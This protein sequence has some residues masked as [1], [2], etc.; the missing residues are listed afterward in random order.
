MI[1]IGDW[2]AALSVAPGVSYEYWLQ[3]TARYSAHLQSIAS[4]KAV[5]YLIAAGND[6]GAVDFYLKRNQP[7]PAMIVAK[8][9]ESR[10]TSTPSPVGGSSALSSNSGGSGGALARH[11]SAY[12]S[13]L[14][15]SASKPLLSAAQ[16]IASGEIQ[17]AVNLLYACEY[18]DIAFAVLVCSQMDTN[19]VKLQMASRCFKNSFMREGLEILS[20]CA[21]NE[22]E[23]GLLLSR[24]CENEKDIQQWLDHANLPTKLAVF[25]TRALEN[26]TIGSDIIA[27]IFYIICLQFDQAATIAIKVLKAHI[28][29]PLE[30][31]SEIKEFLRR[32]KNLRADKLAASLKIQFLSYI[33]WYS[34]HEAAELGNF[35][36]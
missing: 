12:Y 8:M 18:Y 33:L 10:R 27:S 7:K 14:F 25:N 20:T 4:E 15:L 36:H 3:L 22:I 9:S 6:S 29:E 35:L 5:P 17:L 2:E 32:L 23:T 24:Y 16:H 21:N 11:V 26:A 34:A 31:S 28:R 13:N 30:L 1:D 19:D